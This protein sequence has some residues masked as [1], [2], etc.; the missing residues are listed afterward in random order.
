[1][2]KPKKKRTYQDDI[3]SY[4]TVSK[5]QEY[6]RLINWFAMPSPLRK[7]GTLGELAKELSVHAVTLSRWQRVDGFYRDVRTKIKEELRGELPDVLYSLRNKIF[8]EGNSKEIKLFLQW[9]DDF[10]E[11]TEIEHTGE[12]GV[13]PELQKLAAEFND[14]IKAVLSR[15][16]E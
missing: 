3:P 2:A 11:K 16:E 4:Q 7:P 9:V 1:M 12:L 5:Y 6:W 15:K 14:K 13:S 8:K 10:V